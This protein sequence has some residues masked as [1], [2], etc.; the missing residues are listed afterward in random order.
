MYLVDWLS[1]HETND[2][3][4]WKSSILHSG[5]STSYRRSAE[6]IPVEKK[7]TEIAARTWSE[8]TMAFLHTNSFR[9]IVVVFYYIKIVEVG[10]HI[11]L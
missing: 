4:F 9:I 6:I 3:L 5:F 10:I 7:T 2:F 1:V 11:R 8:D